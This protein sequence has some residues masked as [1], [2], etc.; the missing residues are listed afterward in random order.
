LYQYEEFESAVEYVRSILGYMGRGHSCGIHT[1]DESKALKLALE[2]DVARVLLNQAHA[3]GNGGAFNNGLNTTLT[4]GAGTWAG[5]SI[6]E[7]LSYKHFLNTTRLV[8]P[9]NGQPPTEESLFGEYWARYGR[10]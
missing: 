7:N 4:M 10:D 1:T 2:I 6:S 8:R 3:F 5:N 9:T